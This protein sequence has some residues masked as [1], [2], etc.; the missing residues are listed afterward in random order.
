RSR[1]RRRRGGR[2]ARVRAGGCCRG[3]GQ[4]RSGQR[5][6]RPGRSIAPRR[7]GFRGRSCDVPCTGGD[8]L[9]RGGVP[10]RGAV[11]G[12]GGL[13]DLGC[14]RVQRP[15]KSVGGEVVGGF[16]GLGGGSVV[17][18]RFESVHVVVRHCF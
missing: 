18:G 6:R 1:L 9:D 14:R 15:L 10:L 8:V 4:R 16:V 7:Q 2:R 3:D 17:V 11:V 5:C 13:D 12:L